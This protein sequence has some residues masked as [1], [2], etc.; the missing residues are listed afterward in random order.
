MVELVLPL[1]SRKTT[2][3]HVR[4]DGDGGADFWEPING[5]ERQALASVV[6]AA[7]QG[8]AAAHTITHWDLRRRSRRMIPFE[9]GAEG[10]RVTVTLA[11]LDAGG[12]AWRS[13]QDLDVEQLSALF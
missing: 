13:I 6:T 1:G 4:W 5:D 3:L 10:E 2:V 8:R 9:S 7:E 11:Q 12:R